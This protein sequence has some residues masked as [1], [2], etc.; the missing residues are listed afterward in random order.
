MDEAGCGIKHVASQLVAS[1]IHRGPYERIAPV[2]AE[3]ATWIRANGYTPVGP[4]EE[5]YFSE[6]T[7]PPEETV[8]EI[9]IPVA[10]G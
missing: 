9:R 1:T 3:L 10:K 6:P 7:T 2:Y 4:P 8:T 5:V